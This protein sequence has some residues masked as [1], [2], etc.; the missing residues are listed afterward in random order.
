MMTT[1]N[2]SPLVSQ[3]VFSFE[4]INEH[5]PIFN[6]FFVSYVCP[7]LQC[8]WIFELLF[9]SIEF[10]AS[11]M[12]KRMRILFSNKSNND[13]NCN[14]CLHP[15]IASTLFVCDRS[16]GASLTDVSHII[17][18]SMKKWHLKMA[19]M[20]WSTSFIAFFT[21]PKALNIICPNACS[22]TFIHAHTHTHTP[23]IILCIFS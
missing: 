1:Q 16:C 18:M 23:L 15:T 11:Y 17:L 12:R 20:A 13:D 6:S 9:L 14:A 4:V 8:L 22:H 21:R 10:L 7:W 5:F 2:K 19:Q 3:P